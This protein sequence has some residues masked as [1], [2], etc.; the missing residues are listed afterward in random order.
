M[1]MEGKHEENAAQ[2]VLE[3]VLEDE[4][5]AVLPEHRLPLPGLHISRFCV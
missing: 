2:I 4:K 5:A 3:I 1:N